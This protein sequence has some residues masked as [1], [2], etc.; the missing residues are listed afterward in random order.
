MRSTRASW[1]FF[2]NLAGLADPEARL[3]VFPKQRMTRLCEAGGTRLFYYQDQ[4]YA[5]EPRPRQEGC[6][7]ICVAV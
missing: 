6:R 7:V 1:G 5:I 4:C 3:P 2:A